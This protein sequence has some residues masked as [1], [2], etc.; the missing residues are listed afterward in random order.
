M[1]GYTRDELC[2]LGWDRVT[3]PEDRELEREMV[4]E[5]VA[6]LR[7][8]YQVEKRYVRSDGTV[9]WGRLTASLARNAAGEPEYGIGLVEDITRWK[10]REAGRR[11]LVEASRLLGSSLDYE[12]TL[13]NLVQ[14]AVPTLGDWCAIE[15]VVDPEAG[16]WPPQVRRVAIAHHDAERI[17]WVDAVRERRPTDWDAPHGVDPEAADRLNQRVVERV[18]LGG[19]AF[20]SST[21][22]EGRFWLRACIVNPLTREEDVDALLDAVQG[23]ATDL[24]QVTP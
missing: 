4:G 24:L 21:V 11:F 3:H 20:L 7:A 17:A 6:G 15:M 14:A 12:T 1:L 18:Q 16:A 13:Q 5:L 19:E 23:A 9:L 10:R 22:L 8:T 2:E